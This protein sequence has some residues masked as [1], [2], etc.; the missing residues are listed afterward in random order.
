[1]MAM[2]QFAT[3]WI[4]VTQNPQNVKFHF[5]WKNF[6]SGFF[7][8]V[9]SCEVVILARVNYFLV[10]SFHLFLFVLLRFVLLLDWVSLAFRGLSFCLQLACEL[11]FLL[12]QLLYLLLNSF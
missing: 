4:E 9:Q 5:P 11:F 10:L 2:V 3:L 12:L 7:C 8:L 1:L 6:L